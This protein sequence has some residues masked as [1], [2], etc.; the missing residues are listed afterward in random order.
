MGALVSIRPRIA[1]ALAAAVVI[2][3]IAVLNIT[4]LR[5]GLDGFIP[6]I[7]ESAAILTHPIAIV[8]LIV[9][10]PPILWRYAGETRLERAQKTVP[11]LV[12]AGSIVALCGAITLAIP[13]ALPGSVWMPRYQ[14]VVWPA[15]A[16]AVCALLHRLP[17]FP[18][19]TTAFA[20]LFGV[21]LLQCY[22]R[23]FIPNEPPVD[24]IARD[25]LDASGDASSTRTYVRTPPRRHDHGGPSGGSI[26]NSS[27]KYYLYMWERR[28]VRPREFLAARTER[29]F[30][31][32]TNTNPTR[33]VGEI[34][35]AP[36]L[37]RVILWEPLTDLESADTDS[38]LP[39]LPE[40][41]LRQS[42]DLYPVRLYSSWADHYTY[43]RRVYLKQN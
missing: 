5:H 12:I 43:R 32:H 23:V 34:R 39:I 18:L 15:M 20:F 27:G 8:A 4:L 22:G 35:R 33:I 29:E 16:I 28:S 38:L 24:R 3:I 2:G 10:L 40:G 19:R 25:V 31:L 14:G 6:A 37:R 42:Q 17:T 26:L 13:Q 21:N 7:E 1:T 41:W 11:I 30:N 36:R 9:L